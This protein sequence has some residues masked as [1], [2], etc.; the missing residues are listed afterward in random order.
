MNKLTKVGLTALASAVIA[1]PAISAD[2]SISGSTSVSYTNVSTN[3]DTNPFGFGDS[4]TFSTSGELDNGMSISA[5]MEVDGSAMDDRILTLS[6]DEMGTIGIGSS[7]T[8]GGIGKI[9]DKVPT[10]NEEAYDVTDG[11][12]YGLATKTISSTNQLGWTSPSFSG[13]TVTA[14]ITPH[15]NTGDGNDSSWALMYDASSMVDGLAVGYGQAED[16]DTTEAETFYVT[17]TMGGFT[18]GYQD[19]TNDV[20]AATGSDEEAQHMGVSFAV[21]E[22]LSVSLGRQDVEIG[23]NASEEENSG[24]SASYT[25]G[26][27][28]IA[29]FAN[30]SDN[31]GG[32]VGK[33]AEA[34][35]VSVSFSF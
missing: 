6:S 21:N 13:L 7:K 16:G 15:A 22:D 26:S 33:S 34:K 12:D 23:T 11:T 35:G 17:Y 2:W 32:T 31:N 4:L 28:K 9:A 30:K 14:G 18:F 5:S 1:S 19:T 20:A 8:T 10:A 29:M 24:I 3:T 27:M 25:M